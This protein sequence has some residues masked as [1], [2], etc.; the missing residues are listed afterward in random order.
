MEGC[1]IAPWRR[2]VM[3][4]AALSLCLSCALCGCVRWESTSSPDVVGR[5]ELCGGETDGHALTMDAIDEMNGLGL[6][7]FV[8]LDG[9]GSAT[10]SFFDHEVSGGW[11]P[12]SGSAIEI[13]VNGETLECPIVDGELVMSVGEDSLRFSR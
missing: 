11:A 7:C 8:T 9:D 3:L 5:W 12:G 10:V 2:L 13:S 6:T 4:V 1:A